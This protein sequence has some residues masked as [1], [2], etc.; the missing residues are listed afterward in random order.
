MDQISTLCKQRTGNKVSVQE[1]TLENITWERTIWQVEHVE[2]S[3][4]Y[5]EDDCI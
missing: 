3:Y 1:G 4:I 5:K 2:L